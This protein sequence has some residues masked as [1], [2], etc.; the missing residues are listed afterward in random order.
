MLSFQSV[1]Q[2]PLARRRVR[3]AVTLIVP[4]LI[5]GSCAFRLQ[6]PAQLPLELPEIQARV[7]RIV[8]GDTLIIDGGYRVRL[9]GVDTPESVHPDLPPQ[10]Y[11]EEASEYLRELISGKIVRLEFDQERTDRY[12]RLLAYLWLDGLLINEEIISQGYGK[13]VTHFPTSSYYK[14]RFRAAEAEARQAE[15]GIWKPNSQALSA[16]D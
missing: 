3:L 11:A 15:R 2:S 12:G 14:S 1:L 5:I 7:V 13:A 16:D 4:M 9:I 10:P 8:D 6:Q